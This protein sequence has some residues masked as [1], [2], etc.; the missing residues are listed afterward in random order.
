MNLVPIIQNKFK[1]IPSSHVQS[2]QSLI[3]TV[4][5]VL[6]LATL[7]ESATTVVNK[8]SVPSDAVEV[9]SD[10]ELVLSMSLLSVTS[11]TG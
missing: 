11:V 5:V 2:L 9:V 3:K 6:E 4:I 7:M 1:F 10:T 8:L